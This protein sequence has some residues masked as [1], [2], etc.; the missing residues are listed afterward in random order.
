MASSCLIREG[1]AIDSA[2]SHVEYVLL[3]LKLNSIQYIW[4]DLKL[5]NGNALT[6]YFK[7]SNRKTN[8]SINVDKTAVERQMFNLKLGFE[9]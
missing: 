8:S 9:F 5:S 3:H 4:R 2:R 1:H 6:R 7:I